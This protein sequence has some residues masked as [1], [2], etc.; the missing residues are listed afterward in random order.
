LQRHVMAPLAA[1][2]DAA[3]EET[4]AGRRGAPQRAGAW[5]VGGVFALLLGAGLANHEMWRDELQAWMLA[6]V[7]ATPATLLAKLRYEG[8]PKHN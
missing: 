6:R 1:G 8:H 7:S 3:Y 4:A 2:D 5:A